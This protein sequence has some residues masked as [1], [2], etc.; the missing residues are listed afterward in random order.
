MLT[1]RLRTPGLFKGIARGCLV[2]LFTLLILSGAWAQD[3]INIGIISQIDNRPQID[4]IDG[5]KKGLADKGYT[6]D[7]VEYTTFN[8][9]GNAGLV[10]DAVADMRKANVKLI[11][12][13]GT[14]ITIETLK[15]VRDIPVVYACVSYAQSIYEA[16]KKFGFADNYTGALLNAPADILIVL[17][18]KIKVDLGSIGIVY[19][20]SEDNSLRDKDNYEKS[21]AKF[22]IE[23]IIMPYDREDQVVATYQKLA[24]QGV[25]CLLYTKDGMMI[26]HAEEIKP[27]IYKYQIMGLASDAAP[28]QNGLAVLAFTAPAYKVGQLAGEKAYDILAN[29]KKPA[30]LSEEGLKNLELWLNISSATKAK[31]NLPVGIMKLATKVI[32]N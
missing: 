1:I 19:R 32:K 20:I 22:G 23:T 21:C 31:V 26:K 10:K 25:K 2:F 9:K 4:S 11:F 8:C 7:K 5:I 18:L 12:A 29:G 6:Q 16:N 17:A 24:D 27:I 14:S 30:E 3:K 28:V 15:Y 13:I